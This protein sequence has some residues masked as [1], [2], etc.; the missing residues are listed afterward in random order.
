MAKKLTKE[1]R[2]LLKEKAKEGVA[3][4]IVFVEQNN[5]PVIQTVDQLTKVGELLVIIKEKVKGLEQDRKE[6]TDPM[7]E[8]KKRV[9]E[10]FEPALDKLKDLESRIKRAM[11]EYQVE[12]RKIQAQLEAKREVKAVTAGRV[13]TPPPAVNPIVAH[14]ATT[15]RKT[16]KYKVI[17]TKLIPRQYMTHDDDALSA[18]AKALKEKAEVPGIEFYMEESIVMAR[19]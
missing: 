13:Y 1:E 17:N 19:T 9:M 3:E 4:A 11:L 12:Q 10:L 2:L 14:T 16:W 15:T 5:K 18:L 8:A 6:I 7:N